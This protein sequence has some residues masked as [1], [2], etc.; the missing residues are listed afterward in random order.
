M[1]DCDGSYERQWGY[2]NAIA[3]SYWRIRDELILKTIVGRLKSTASHRI[4]EIGTG[5]GHIA[6]T[7]P[8]MDGALSSLKDQG[9]E[10]DYDSPI[11]R[12]GA[13]LDW[14]G[15]PLA[16]GPGRVWVLERT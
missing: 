7:T 3:A 13:T 10:P 2:S 16:C 14:F 4:L 6:I 5:Y 12:L 8:D 1:R 15:F 11:N 9:I